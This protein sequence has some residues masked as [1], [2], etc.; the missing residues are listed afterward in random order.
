MENLRRQTIPP[1]LLAKVQ[2]CWIRAV[3]PAVAEQASPT[4]ERA[5]VVTVSCRSAVWSS[6]LSML[7]GSLLTQVNAAL[8]GDAEVSGLKFT[9][10][11]GGGSS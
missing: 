6:E 7:S 11:A 4:F 2:A 8:P 3:G 9:T 10:R 1:T 5:G